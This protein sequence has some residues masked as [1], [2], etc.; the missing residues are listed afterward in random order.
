ML[1]ALWKKEKGRESLS[2]YLFCPG[3][4]LPDGFT[5]VVVVC[6]V[7]PPPVH[8]GCCPPGS[9]PPPFVQLVSVVSEVIFAEAGVTIDVAST[10]NASANATARVG[11]PIFLIM[12]PG[13]FSR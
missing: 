7:S 3:G 2:I 11:M 5:F 4:A 12:L 9:L 10:A 6:C 13:M 8:D 1:P